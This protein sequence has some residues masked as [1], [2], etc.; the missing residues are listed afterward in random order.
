[1]TCVEARPLLDAYFDSELD[2]SSSL[3]VER[4]LSECA[5]CSAVLRNLELLRK[6]LTPDVFN[7]LS[8]ADLQHLDRSIRKLTRSGPAWKHAWNRPAIFA[9]VAAALVLAMFLPSRFHI[10]N[11]SLDRELVDSHVRSLMANHLVD[12]PSSDHHTVKPWFQGKV[13]FAPNV[14]DLADQGFTLI[15]GRL[16]IIDGRPTAAIVYKRRGHFVN[17][18]TARAEGTGPS[19]VFS[20]VDGYQLAH[21]TTSGLE[22]WVVSDLNRA[23]LQTFI[24]LVR[25]R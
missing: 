25:S 1:M 4:H 10:P 8:R 9:A 11:G 5:M 18:W 3:N 13:D 19:P 12:V 16:D 22:R 2:L 15:G 20:T 23:E 17:L 7:Q 24:D 14:P 21:W 6:E